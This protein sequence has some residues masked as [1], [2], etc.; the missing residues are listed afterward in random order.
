MDHLQWGL[1]IAFLPRFQNKTC[2]REG[3][4]GRESCAGDSAV[5][6]GVNGSDGLMMMML[7]LLTTATRPL[8]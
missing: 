2:Q 1:N 6:D 4:V 7:L 3:C 5:G 8:N